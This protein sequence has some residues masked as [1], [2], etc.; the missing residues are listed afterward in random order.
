MAIR[1]MRINV[2]DVMRRT[3]GRGG[4]CRGVWPSSVPTTYLSPG[5]WTRFRPVRRAVSSVVPRHRSS[6]PATARPAGALQ[7]RVGPV[8]RVC[9]PL[10]TTRMHSRGAGAVSSGH[11][12]RFGSNWHVVGTDVWP[13]APAGRSHCVYIV[14]VSPVARMAGDRSPQ[15]SA[16]GIVPTKH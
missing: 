4:S 2:S 1:P 8:R 11:L 9:G 12:T 7:P 6:G 3:A 13:F 16:A 15:I 14:A 10:L 5:G